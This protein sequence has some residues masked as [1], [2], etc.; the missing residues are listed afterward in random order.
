MKR[1]KRFNDAVKDIDLAKVY[2]IDE[3]VKVLK[4]VSPAKFDETFELALKMGVDPRKADQQVRGSNLLPNGTGKD[5]KVLVFAKGDKAKEALE[6]GADFVGGDELAEKIKEGWTGFNQVIA[7]PDMMR[8][9]G[10]LG[11]ILGPRGL[12][13]APKA[14]TVTTEV[15]KTVKEVKSGRVEF[16]VD[17]S[18]NIHTIFGKISFSVEHL[19]ENFKSLLDAIIKSKP[20]AMKGAYIKSISI[21]TSMGPGLKLESSTVQ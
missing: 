12:M 7:T 10:R 11:R 5:V 21:S 20:A 9:V 17:K 14:G 8:V 15:A 1:S 2:S 18:S 3:A 19:V 16:K 4:A 6:A 13:P